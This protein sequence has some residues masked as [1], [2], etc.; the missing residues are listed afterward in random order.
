M[1]IENLYQNVLI[2]PSKEQENELFIVSGYASATFANRHLEATK[3]FDTKINL[4]IGM[5]SKYSDHYAYIDLCKTYSDRFFPYYLRGAPPVHTKAYGWYNRDGRPIIGFSGSA[6]YS[7]PGFMS[8]VQINQ[9]TEDN[10]EEIRSFFTTL[11]GRAKYIPDVTIEPIIPELSPSSVE[12]SVRPGQHTW[13]VPD[14]RVRISFLARNGS[15]PGRSGLNWGQRP[16]QNREPNQAYLS[17]KG[18]SRKEGFLPELA[19]TFTLITDDHTSLDCVV[20]QQGRKGIHT[21]SDNSIMG[22][23][24]RNRLGVPLGEFVTIEHLTNYGRTDYTIEKIDEET[25]MLDFS[26]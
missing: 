15:L 20:A 13:E 7:Q 17:L 1:I 9:L 10:P 19:F 22:K 25:F 23:Y 5:P 6:N 16:E 21:T 4:L 12:S 8:N 24:F 2:D 26:V 14:K 18:D 3:T 11:K